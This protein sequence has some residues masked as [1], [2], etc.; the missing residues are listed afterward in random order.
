MDNETIKTANLHRA[1]ASRSKAMLL[2]GHTDGQVNAM[3]FDFAVAYMKQ[4]GMSEDWLT[5][6][7]REP[8]FWGWWKQQ[9]SL[10]D[11]VFCYEYAGYQGR[12]EVRDELRGRYEKL[13]ADI[14]K[15]P[16]EIVYEKIHS[17]Y[18]VAGREIMHRITTKNHSY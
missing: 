9:W 18:E 17:G 2:T 10:V 4:M 3:M 7:L 13:H 11:E 1:A 6:W 16:D 12:E 5:L 14:D 15:F 8:L